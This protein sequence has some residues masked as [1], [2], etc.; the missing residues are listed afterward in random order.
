ML[1]MFPQIVG[2]ALI[3]FSPRD[4]YPFYDLCGRIYPELG[5]H[6]DQVIGG[7]IIWIPP[8]MMSVLALVLVLNVLRRSE[9][10][11]SEDEDDQD[12]TRRSSMPA[13]GPAVSAALPAR[14]FC[15][16][17][18]SAAPKGVTIEKP[19]IRLI[20]KARPAAGYF[21]LHNDSD[22]AVTLTGASSSACGLVMLHQWKEENGVEKMLPVKS[23]TVQPHGTLT[24]APGGYH[25]MC[26]K[27]QTWRS[28]RACR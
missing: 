4:L 26:M 11:T 24:F 18:A 8:A 23:I 7:L 3:S 28:A 19:W 1:V 14:V 9:E 13:G 16:P 6:Y 10:R 12:D 22:K 15:A 27:P 2:G 5:A 20:I 25:L 21:T 17:P